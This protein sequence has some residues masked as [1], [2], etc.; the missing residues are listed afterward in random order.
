M[1][2]TKKLILDLEAN[3]HAGDE[4]MARVIAEMREH[5]DLVEEICDLDRYRSL[6]RM[7]SASFIVEAMGALKEKNPELHGIL[8]PCT[9]VPAWHQ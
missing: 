4:L 6:S 1:T 8:F 2:D 7:A 3:R 5:S 9:P